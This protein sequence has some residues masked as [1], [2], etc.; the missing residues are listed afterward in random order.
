MD[1]G[2]YAQA[3]NRCYLFIYLDYAK[4]FDTVPHQRLIRQIY[5]LGIQGTAIDF[6]RAFLTGR[7]Q[8]VR[9]NRSYS[10]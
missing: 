10:T 1:R 6:I 3:S 8:R 4:A 5:S 7:R 2:T 9:L